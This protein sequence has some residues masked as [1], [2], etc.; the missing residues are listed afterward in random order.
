MDLVVAVL[1]CSTAAVADS[2]GR[3]SWMKAP[4]AAAEAGIQGGH[5][6]DGKAIQLLLSCQLLLSRDLRHK[7]PVVEEADT[8]DTSSARHE[9]E[10]LAAAAAFV[11]DYYYY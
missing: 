3:G 9:Y 11:V 8:G 4:L 6:E 5:G 10:V 2:D 1:G 7:K